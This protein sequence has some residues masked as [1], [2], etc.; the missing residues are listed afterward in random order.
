MGALKRNFTAPDGKQTNQD[1][2][3]VVDGVVQAQK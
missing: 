3:W 2:V 1:G